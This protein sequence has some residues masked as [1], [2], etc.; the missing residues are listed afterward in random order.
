MHGDDGWQLGARRRARSR[1]RPR[2][3]LPPPPLPPSRRCA[4]CAQRDATRPACL[5]PYATAMPLPSAGPVPP[6]Q[7]S[8]PPAHSDAALRSS[9][10][11]PARRA[12]A[13][14]HGPRGA[15]QPVADRSVRAPAHQRRHLQRP[16]GGARRRLLL[17]RPRRADA[18]EW[19][20]VD[21]GRRVRQ[22]GKGVRL[23]LGRGARGAHGI[24]GAAALP[25]S[26]AAH[27]QRDHPQPAGQPGACREAAG[28]NTGVP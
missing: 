3:Q 6:A 12:Q 14:R 9:R 4:A 5:T 10:P 21:A 18:R 28:G 8:P 19:Q 15:A 11:S 23:L 22:A 16:H 17:S 2:L 26:Q 20:Q 24:R 25:G 1:A 7:R 13:G 27:D